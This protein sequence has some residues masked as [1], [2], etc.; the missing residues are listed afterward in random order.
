MP[1]HGSQPQLKRTSARGIVYGAPAGRRPV[2]RGL[3]ERRYPYLSGG[4]RTGLGPGTSCRRRAA[5]EGAVSGGALRSPA[6]ARILIVA[7]GC[8][9]R[10]LAGGLVGEGH[11]VRV[12]TR[13]ESGRAAIE[14][15][16][17]E[18]WIGTPERLG[19]LRAALESVTI[20]CW[21]LGTS[22]AEEVLRALHASRL[23]F[24]LGQ[25]IDTTVRGFVYETSGTVPGDA[26]VEG[27]RIVRMVAERN[28]IPTAFIGA[29]PRGPEIWLNGRQRRDRR[30]ARGPIDAHLRSS[31]RAIGPMMNHDDGRSSPIRAVD[32]GARRD[33]ARGV[34]VPAVVWGQLHRRRHRLRPA[35]RRS[36]RRPV[37]QRH[38]A[39]LSWAS[40]TPL[41]ARSPAISS[42]R[43][44]PTRR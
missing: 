19:T 35:G 42:R 15:T 29:D 1:M 17:A 3:F 43:S 36:G 25:V 9:G 33:R 16:G 6:V 34:G 40:T 7:G 21:L 4:A 38:A 23:E 14:A 13:N 18:C 20:V 39:E 44:A 11:A 8:R 10:Q 5:G 37:R 27:E 22:L 28:A 32:L 26:L 24:F 31:R 30:A 2:G 41:S 12:T